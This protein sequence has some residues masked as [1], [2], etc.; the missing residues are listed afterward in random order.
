[1]IE[2]RHAGQSYA[3]HISAVRAL[4]VI[5]CGKWPKSM[6]SGVM[7]WGGERITM[8]E[9]ASMAGGLQFYDDTN[10]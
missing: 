2:M 6:T 10:N 7:F 4:V 5:H 3:N 9:F 1:M 8:D